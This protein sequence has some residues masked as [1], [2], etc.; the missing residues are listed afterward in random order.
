MQENVVYTGVNDNMVR[1]DEIA[2]FLGVGIVMSNL[3]PQRH[4][5]LHPSNAR[6]LRAIV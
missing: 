5:V 4:V 2:S 3:K 1:A 6:Y